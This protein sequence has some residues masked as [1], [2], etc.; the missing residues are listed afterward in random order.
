MSR[1]APL[2]ETV[3]PDSRGAAETS[4]L[5]IDHVM[6]PAAVPV[7]LNRAKTAL[8]IGRKAAFEEVVTVFEEGPT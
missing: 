7:I 8:V 2:V 3:T 5:R 6:A 1:L 4:W